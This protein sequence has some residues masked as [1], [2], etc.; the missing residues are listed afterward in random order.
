M[1]NTYPDPFEGLLQRLYQ[2]RDELLAIRLSAYVTLPG[3][4]RVQKDVEACLNS[5]DNTLR[6]CFVDELE[7]AEW[8]Q[9]TALEV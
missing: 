7:S 6:K 1:K 4:V 3:N 9:I 5:I 8:P 2:C